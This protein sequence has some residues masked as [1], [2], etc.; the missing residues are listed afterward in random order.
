[1]IGISLN[2]LPRFSHRCLTS[3]TLGLKD[4]RKLLIRVYATLVCYHEPW[5]GHTSLYVLR[6][7]KFSRPL[8][9]N[10]IKTYENRFLVIYIVQSKPLN[11]MTQM[12]SIIQSFMK[13]VFPL[14]PS[15]MFATDILNAFHLNR[16]LKVIR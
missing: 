6:L 12:I 4:T 14:L 11:R 8:L 10:N 2:P 5:K 3:L 1:M 15:S 13:L 16:S 9:N 7:P